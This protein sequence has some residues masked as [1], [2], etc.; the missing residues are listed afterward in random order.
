MSDYVEGFMVGRMMSPAVL[1]DIK[2]QSSE[3]VKYYFQ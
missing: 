3:P 2:S 1:S